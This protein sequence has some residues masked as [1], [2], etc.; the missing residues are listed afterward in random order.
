MMY[1]KG[2]IDRLCVR[3]NSGVYTIDGY[4]CTVKTLG[5]YVTKSSTRSRMEA[6]TEALKYLGMP[7]FSDAYRDD[8]VAEIHEIGEQIQ[9]LSQALID[10]SFLDD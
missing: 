5:M 1:I 10:G 8:I 6:L 9:K 3:T 7:M 2:T 4:I